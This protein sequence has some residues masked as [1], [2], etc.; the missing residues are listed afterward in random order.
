MG[1]DKNVF[2]FRLTTVLSVLAFWF[3]WV[4]PSHANVAGGGTGTGANVTVTDNGGTV[5]LANGIVS[6]TINKT[7]GS[8]TNFTYNGTN[9][10]AGA[11]AGEAFTSMTPADL[12]SQTPSIH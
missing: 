2:S 6:F 10:L 12:F 3:A 5:V 9:L 11:T 8:I 7:S 1:R 4:N